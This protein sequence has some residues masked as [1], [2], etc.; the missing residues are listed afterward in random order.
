MTEADD[1]TLPDGMPADYISSL[2]QFRCQPAVAWQVD[3]WWSDPSQGWTAGSL[4]VTAS[5]SAVAVRKAAKILA[6]N[7][8]KVDELTVRRKV[9][10]GNLAGNA[11]SDHLINRIMKPFSKG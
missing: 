7:N 10:T 8:A 1:C 6:E 3:Y 5:T 9:A 4:A 11:F 2:C